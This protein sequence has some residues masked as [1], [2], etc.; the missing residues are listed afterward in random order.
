MK[1]TRNKFRD[2]GMERSVRE[3]FIGT[4]KLLS[5]V[6][7]SRQGAISEPYGGGPTGYIS[8]GENG[9]V[10]AILMKSDRQRIGG[11]LEGLFSSRRS[12]RAAFVMSNLRGFFR[13]TKNSLVSTAYAGTWEVRGQQVFHQ[14]CAALVPDWHDIEL[15][16][17]FWFDGSLMTLVAHYPDGAKITLVWQRFLQGS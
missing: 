8:Y 2:F 7:V 1:Q 17:E 5:M 16:R 3:S 11:L 4:W 14:V 15:S 13:V 10:H 6:S 12:S 9:F